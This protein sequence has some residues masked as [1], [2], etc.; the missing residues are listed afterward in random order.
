MQWRYKRTVDSTPT[1]SPQIPWLSWKSIKN[2]LVE[3]FIII[4]NDIAL[5]LT[6]LHKAE[7]SKIHYDHVHSDMIIRRNKF[8]LG[9]YLFS[10]FFV[11]LFYACICILVH[12]IRSNRRSVSEW[13]TAHRH[14][15]IIQLV[16]N[17]INILNLLHLVATT[18]KSYINLL[19]KHRKGGVYM[20]F[21]FFSN[22]NLLKVPKL[23]IKPLKTIY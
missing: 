19:Y 12:F 21:S 10:V 22:V 16:M 5:Y 2:K 18:G 4:V 6:E 13:S 8:S 23:T 3:I 7:S 17:W 15:K 14:S 20:F 1:A 11:Q 9:F